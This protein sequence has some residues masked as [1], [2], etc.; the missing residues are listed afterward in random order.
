MPTLVNIKQGLQKLV[1]EKPSYLT[2]TED[3]RRKT[4]V[5]RASYYNPG[6][7]GLYRTPTADNQYLYNMREWTN[8]STIANRAYPKEMISY[9]NPARKL[10]DT[11][12][13][14]LMNELT[15]QGIKIPDSEQ[16]TEF[17]HQVFRENNFFYLMQKLFTLPAV[18]GD[19]YCRVIEDS[20]KKS[21]IR[22]QVYPADGVYP[23]LDTQQIEKEQAI[24]IYY[25]LTLIKNENPTKPHMF[26]EYP[27]APHYEALMP[28][29][30]VLEV[31]GVVEEE[32]SWSYNGKIPMVHFPHMVF[33]D[34]FGLPTI[35]NDVLDDIDHI[36]FLYTSMWM[37]AKRMFFPQI[38]LKGIRLQE[39][40]K[41]GMTKT[42]EVPDP[43]ASV[44]VINF[45]I[46]SSYLQF[47]KDSIETVRQKL[48]HY[49]VEQMQ[50]S[51]AAMTK[52]SQESR[53]GTFI[54]YE[55]RVENCHKNS[56]E[57]LVNTILA[58]AKKTPSDVEVDI[59]MGSPISEA[60][61][62]Q[63]DRINQEIEIFGRNPA[64]IERGL[65]TLHMEPEEKEVIMKANEDAITEEK[66][67]KKAEI[68]MRNSTG[69]R[70]LDRIKTGPPPD[71]EVK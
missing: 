25:D 58:V 17:I 69:N 7:E 70:I 34:Y 59:E 15:P 35:P 31:D 21:G 44:E 38:L 43:Q 62:N 27:A 1:R 63:L 12:V 22:L 55:K 30:R 10:V 66:D 48:P 16:M 60:V 32:E 49:E 8:D 45:P 67:N 53:F 68:A 6:M 61:S 29:G 18:Q 71:Q 50:T 23:I 28:E 40:M 11:D 39:D 64:T 52:E 33:D 65:D 57:K 3:E 42:H 4:Y 20:E 51:R 13:A 19:A 56:I 41:L 46:D 5:I 24:R 54:N 14:A 47:L 37:Q 36:N 26:T 2:N 9:F